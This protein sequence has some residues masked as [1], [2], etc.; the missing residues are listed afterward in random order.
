MKKI[1]LAALFAT[2]FTSISVAQH[3]DIEF[4]FE[5]PTVPGAVFE[6]LLDEVTNENIQFAEGSFIPAGPFATSDNPGFI[7]PDEVGEVLTV[8]EGDQVFVNVLDAS[9]F[10]NVGVGLSLI[11]I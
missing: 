4:G 2:L 1:I 8:N 3:A 10:S 6:V 5:D 9:A 7:T 11:H